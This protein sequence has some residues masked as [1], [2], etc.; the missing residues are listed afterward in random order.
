M[1]MNARSVLIILSLLILLSLITFGLG[2]ALF[3]LIFSFGMAYLLFPLIKKIEGIG[4][5]RIYAVSGVLAI[6]SIFIVLTLILI[7]P[8]LI[9]DS[10]DFFHELPQNASKS[11]E[12]IESIVSRFGFDIEIS[13]EGLKTFIYEHTSDISGDLVKRVSSTVKGLFSNILN[14]LLGLL[15][16][17][18]IPLFFFY[19]INDFENILNGMKSL[20]PQSF[21]PKLAHYMKLSN[22]VLSG[23]IRGQLIVAGLLGILYGVGLTVVG[24]RFGLLIGLISGF[25]SI[26]PYAGLTIGFVAA[27][28]IGFANFTGM[29]TIFGIIIVFV[30]VQVLEGVVITP[31]LVGDKVGLSALVTILALIIG[32]NLFGLLGMVIA[33][34]A[35]A[36]IKSI[37]IDLLE[38]YQKLDVYNIK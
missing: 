5:K 8:K 7:A 27:M 38:E 16:L 1:N 13:R 17:F 24:L 10:K 12:K 2:D 30:T 11:I 23:Y 3:P 18:L 9:S 29:D 15:N 22:Q 36:V 28:M 35:A 25:I 31:K 19:L 32:G 6:A 37:F 20:I 21:Q 26:I 14:W 4:V 33:I 34:P